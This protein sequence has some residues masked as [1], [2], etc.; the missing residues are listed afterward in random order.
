MIILVAQE[1]IAKNKVI[2]RL[3]HSEENK[4]I[5]RTKDQ[6][7]LPCLEEQGMTY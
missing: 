7:V 3:I 2:M 5:F 4:Q 1:I 6:P